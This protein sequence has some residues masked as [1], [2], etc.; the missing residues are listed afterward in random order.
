MLGKPVDFAVVN[1]ADA[2]EKEEIC[3]FTELELKASE[4]VIDELL[5]REE[6]LRETVEKLNSQINQY[7]LQIKGLKNNIDSIERQGSKSSVVEAAHQDDYFQDAIEASFN[8]E[9]IV[10]TETEHRENLEELQSQVANYEEQIAVLERNYHDKEMDLRRQ[11]EELSIEK[12]QYESQKQETEREAAA[13]EERLRSQLEELSKLLAETESREKDAQSK[14]IEREALLCEQLE[15][16]KREVGQ[17]KMSYT[18]E[19]QRYETEINQLRRQLDERQEFSKDTIESNSHLKKLIEDL[20]RQ[21]NQLEK[22]CASLRSDLCDKQEVIVKQEKKMELFLEERHTDVE[23]LKEQVEK[24][25]VEHS[26]KEHSLQQTMLEKLS[27]NA[28]EIEELRLKLQTQDDHYRRTVD[29]YGLRER[30]LS[31]T[32]QDVW[33]CLSQTIA[34][35]VETQQMTKVSSTQDGISQT[36]PLGYEMVSQAAQTDKVELLEPQAMLNFQLQLKDLSDSL[37]KARNEAAAAIQAREDFAVLNKDLNDSNSALRSL[38]EMLGEEQA[39]SKAAFMT[40]EAEAARLRAQLIQ[41]SAEARAKASQFELELEEKGLAIVELGRRADEANESRALLDRLCAELKDRANRLEAQNEALTEEIISLRADKTRHTPR[42]SPRS[43]SSNFTGFEREIQGTAGNLGMQSEPAKGTK[44]EFFA[45]LHK[46]STVYVGNLS[47]FTTE[48]QIHELFSK[49]G[50]VKRIIM[51]LDRQKKTPCGFCFVD[52]TKLDDRP[53]RADI[54]PGY[55]PDRQYGRGRSGGQVRDEH[56]QEYDPGR[57]GWGPQKQREMDM[58]REE[59]QRDVYSTMGG[60]VPDGSGNDYYSSRNPE[61]S[62]TKKRRT[63]DDDEDYEGGRQMG[64]G[65]NLRSQKRLAAAVLKCGQRKIWLDPNET[66]VISGEN[67]RKGILKLKKDGLIIKKKTA[68]HSRSRVRVLHAAKR[69]GRHTGTGK[70][71]GTAEARMPTAVLWMRRQ[72]VLRRLLRKYRESGKID[73]HLYHVLYLK[74]KGNVFKNKRV[75]M[76]Y[77]HKA[78]ADKAR[79][80]LLADQAE[81]HRNRNKAARE[82][83]EQRIASKKEALLGGAEEKNYQEALDVILSAPSDLRPEVQ[84]EHAYCLYRLQKNDECQRV[85]EASTIRNSSPAMAHLELQLRYRMEQ[86]DEADRI[87]TRILT[88]I[89]QRC[90][91]V[92]REEGSSEEMINKELAVILAQLGYVYQRLGREAEAEELYKGILNNKNNEAALVAIASNNLIAIHGSNDLFD[93]IKRYRT[94]LGKGLD[95][96]LTSQQRKVISLN[97][98]VLSLLMKKFSVC[99]EQVEKLVAAYGNDPSFA[100]MHAGI[101]VSEKNGLSKAVEYLKSQ[102]AAN[103]SS[104]LLALALVE[105]LLRT[106]AIGESIAVLEA[107]TSSGSPEACQKPFV[108]S[109]LANLYKEARQ[110]DKAISVITDA[111][112]AWRKLEE[113]EYAEIMRRCAAFKLGCCRFTDA[114]KDYEMLVRSDSNDSEAIA[115]LIQSYAEVDLQTAEGYLSLL[116]PKSSVFDPVTFDLDALEKMPPMKK[117]KQKGEAKSE[118]EALTK[119]KKVRKRKPRTNKVFD[120]SITPDPE[121]W[122]PKHERSAFKKKQSKKDLDK[123][124]QGAAVA[125]GGLGGTGSANILGRKSQQQQQQQAAAVDNDVEM[126][127][128]PKKLQEIHVTPASSKKKKKGKK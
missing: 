15:S 83:R 121:R 56:R 41:A 26:Q 8:D 10:T 14:L 32:L 44:E 60:Y 113:A 79:A 18:E 85:I 23:R 107:F 49:C 47:F 86:Y 50:E 112:A 126:K 98:C 36:D 61:S 100:V 99:K 124:P 67:S 103:P 96:K 5:Q 34:S 62:A 106:N 7:E 25:I 59:R 38:V 4:G 105:L 66:S 97:G 110:L 70:R 102:L 54:D 52:G 101:L 35:S 39:V 1:K 13:N 125:G 123:G 3:S 104:A 58:M 74:S 40:L 57:G 89:D 108:V 92:M 19:L 9:Q 91:D 109:V 118:S 6:T 33:S 29:D 53:I 24:L 51:G 64:K 75:L 63:R 114:A 12:Q 2:H 93:S 128:A 73:K 11:L 21:N 81:A 120:K 71:R 119:P 84:F 82:R 42:S 115:G 27:E 88:E 22:D 87:A 45:K 111:S 95:Q 127:D 30:D 117:T 20:E 80:K 46:S 77:I 68:I 37:Q 17:T 78:K 16:A 55:E 90:V 28:V 116:P 48:E 94:T 76:E 65:I 72:R 122:L 31:A 43:I 69:A